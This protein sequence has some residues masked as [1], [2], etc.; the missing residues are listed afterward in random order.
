[1]DLS[2]PLEQYELEVAFA[3]KLGVRRLEPPR[4]SVRDLL[5]QTLSSSRPTGRELLGRWPV[6]LLRQQFEQIARYEEATPAGEDHAQLAALLLARTEEISLAL[7][8]PAP[9]DE[10]LLSPLL[11]VLES[12]QHRGWLSTYI[13]KPKNP[14]MCLAEAILAA[15]PLLSDCEFRTR[16]RRTLRRIRSQLKRPMA[17]DFRMLRESRNGFVHGR[18]ECPRDEYSG[19]VESTLGRS[20]VAAWLDEGGP[21][22]RDAPVLHLLLLGAG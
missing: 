15:L 14:T 11:D 22:A 6:E 17:G 5:N 13:K 7:L 3:A 1:M 2:D 4:R 9:G 19:F 8:L 18:A 21:S 16:L 10:Q 12:E 20:S